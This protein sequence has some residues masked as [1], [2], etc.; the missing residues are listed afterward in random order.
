[1]DE[2]ANLCELFCAEIQSLKRLLTA[3]QENQNE[4]NDFNCFQ[5]NQCLFLTDGLSIPPAVMWMFALFCMGLLMILLFNSIGNDSTF[6]K[7][8]RQD[9]SLNDDNEDGSERRLTL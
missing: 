1:M 9:S 2:N 3:L 4:C 7:Y 8:Y 5:S 6:A